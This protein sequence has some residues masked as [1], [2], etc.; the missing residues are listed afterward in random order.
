MIEQCQSGYLEA[1]RIAEAGMLARLAV[2][3]Q[4]SGIV[5][6]DQLLTP[7]NRMRQYTQLEA[8]TGNTPLDPWHIQGGGTIWIKRES[9]NPTES[10]YD[11]ASVAVLKR[12]EMDG[13]IKPGDR[14]LEG[15]S[16]SAGRS[17]AWACS[18]LGYKLDIIVPHK[19]EIPAER[20]R[21]MKALGAN[22]IH[23]DEKGGI[24][25]VRRKFRRMLVETK[26]AGYERDDYELE[27]KPII[28]FRKDAETIVAPDHSEIIITPNAFGT[29]GDEVVAQLPEGARIDTF[30]STLGNGATLK[31]ISERLRAA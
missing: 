15:T 5:P 27:G 12:L 9:E 13:F 7:E 22:V 18:R 6:A 11:R 2:R 21:D 3:E 20:V 16:G 23:A 1:T 28:V 29:I 30:I 4:A 14:I 25:K 10:H 31:G 19:E 8:M 24:L 26:R 17:F